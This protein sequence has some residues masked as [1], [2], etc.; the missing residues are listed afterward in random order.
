[1]GQSPGAVPVGGE[2]LAQVER[3]AG[4]QGVVDE[5]QAGDE[6]DEVDV[7]RRRLMRPVHIGRARGDEGEARIPEAA[8]VALVRRMAGA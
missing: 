7:G 5:R 3:L 1:M 2:R 4:V 6:F 8:G